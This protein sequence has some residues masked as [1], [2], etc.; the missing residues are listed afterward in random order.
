MEREV[1]MV[2]G[3]VVAACGLLVAIQLVIALLVYTGTY[4]CMLLVAL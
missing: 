2:L 3:R 4:V 1:S